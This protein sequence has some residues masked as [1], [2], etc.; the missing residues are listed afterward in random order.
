M[1]I[2]SL[3]IKF[4]YHIKFT[5]MLDNVGEGFKN[6]LYAAMV[7]IIAYTV[8]FITS[9]HPV[10]L[11]ILKPLLN[12]TD[13]LSILWYPICTFVSAL[14]NTDFAYYQYGVL[15]L[16]YATSYFTSASVYPLCG[17]ITQAMYGIALMVAPT[18]VVLLFSLSMLEIRYTEWLKKMWLPILEIVLVI[19]IS[20]IIVLQFL[21]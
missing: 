3:A 7:C 13:G 16:T 20:F 6:T 17:L 5:D 1:I 19:F 12:L 8:L 15:N 18:S 11:T 14:C 9:G 4:T 10:I 21:I 2:A